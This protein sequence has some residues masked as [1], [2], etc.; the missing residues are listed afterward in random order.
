MPSRAALFDFDGTLA[1]SFTAIT[2]STNHVRELYGLP[3]LPEAEVRV[4][5]GFGLD[6]LLR[7]LVPVAPT[8][9]AV[10]K[11]RVHH[12]TV[13][14]S[15]TRLMPGVGE[16]IPEL[17]R[18]GYRMAVCSNKKVEFTRDLV[19]G[20]GLGPY[21]EAVLGPEDV[22]DRPKPDPAMLVEGL[23]RLS[24]APHDAVYVGDMGID[25]QTARAAGV[26][27]WIVLGGA[28]GR[29]DVTKTGPDRVLPHFAEVL[30][31]LPAVRG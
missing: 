23:K 27:V 30:E 17:A 16:A 5:V 11:Y 7:N 15:L 25:V 26:P 24:A 10:A 9:E 8:A 20:L 2:A 31:H 28:S 6:D 1:D 29:E 13:I 12:Q 21:F 19:A 4:H 22:G 18:R 3:P 14:H